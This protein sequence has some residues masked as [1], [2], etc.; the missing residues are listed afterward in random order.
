MVSVHDGGNEARKSPVDLCASG[1]VAHLHTSAL[2]ANQPSLSEDL[3]V[4]RERR[5]WN[6]LFADV[7]EI[8]AIARTL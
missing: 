6:V 3:E 5:F 2:T 7:Q 8:R 1:G 4:L